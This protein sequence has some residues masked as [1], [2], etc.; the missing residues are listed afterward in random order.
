MP[1]VSETLDL[2]RAYILAKGKT[3]NYADWAVRIMNVVIRDT[4]DFNVHEVTKEDM[5]IYLVTLRERLKRTSFDSYKRGMKVYF[6]WSS[7][8]Y[9]YTNPLEDIPYPKT[10]LAEDLDMSTETF[11]AMWALADARNRALMAFALSSM[12]RASEI[13]QLNTDKMSLTKRT[14]RI[15]G[16]GQ[17]ARNIFWDSFAWAH[18]ERWL[19]VREQNSVWV[20]TPYDSK[21]PLTYWGLRESFRRLAAKAKI[22]ADESSNLHSVRNLGAVEAAKKGMSMAELSQ[23]MGHSVTE[24]T[25]R[26]AR[27][28]PDTMKQQSEKYD[29]VRGV[30]ES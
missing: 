4:R 8:H 21:E 6:E 18:V 30:L 7:N 2:F 19:A 29:L 10:H 15:I 28:R 5:I 25:K 14:Q 1:T 13:L 3:D 20:F 12:A 22:E 17:K 9:G 26:Y 16:K 11:Q 27:Y 23:R 24:V